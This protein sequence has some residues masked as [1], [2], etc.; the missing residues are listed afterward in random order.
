MEKN[1]RRVE[2][3]RK[4]DEDIRNLLDVIKDENAHISNVYRAHAHGENSIRKINVSKC[5][6]S[7]NYAILIFPDMGIRYGRYIREIYSKDFRQFDVSYENMKEI[8]DK[9]GLSVELFI[10]F[11]VIDS[12]G[13]ESWPNNYIE[14]F[15]P[16]EI[17]RKLELEERKIYES[18]LKLRDKVPIVPKYLGF[19]TELPREKDIF[20]YKKNI[21]TK[22]KNIEVAT[23]SLVDK[24]QA[25]FKI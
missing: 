8:A 11:P 19:M 6:C 20:R 2:Y 7:K 21:Q 14:D 15:H 13:V 5:I 25:N 3:E 22:I 1:K 16:S 10:H 4:L 12:S 24:I 23:Q 17:A 18:Y 9:N